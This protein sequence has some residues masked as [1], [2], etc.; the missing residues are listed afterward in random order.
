MNIIHCKALS[1]HHLL[2]IFPKPCRQQACF[3]TRRSSILK[4]HVFVLV[5][6]WA[7]P[8]KCYLKLMKYSHNY[9]SLKM[10]QEKLDCHLRIRGGQLKGKIILTITEEYSLTIPLFLLVMGVICVWLLPQLNQSFLLVREIT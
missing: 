6:Q 8:G 3:L 1:W 7:P 2:C 9:I 4:T 5:W 10:N